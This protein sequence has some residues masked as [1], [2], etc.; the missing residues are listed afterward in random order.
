MLS[1][2]DNNKLE[3]ISNNKSLENYF[4]LHAKDPKWFYP[5]K[6]K[7]YFSPKKVPL[8]VETDQKGF[9]NV[10]DWSVLNYIESISK[11]CKDTDIQ[12]E[13]LSI[14]YNTT[15]LH[16]NSNFALDNYRVWW[17]FTKIL[18]NLPTVTVIKYLSDKNIDIGGNW[19]KGWLTSKFDNS[20][21]SQYI[22]DSILPKFLTNELG[23]RVIAESIIRVITDVV[24]RPKEISKG[25]YKDVRK[26]PQTLA[27]H[28]WL[29]R[30]ME[31]NADKIGALCSENVVFDLAAKLKK[32]FLVDRGDVFL[33]IQDHETELQFEISRINNDAILDDFNFNIKLFKLIK[34]TSSDSVVE[35]ERVAIT[36][37]INECRNKSDFYIALND[38]VKANFPNIV[39][40]DVEKADIERR[41]QLLF[42]DNSYIFHRSLLKEKADD[43]REAVGSLIFAI[44][45]ILISKAKHKPEEAK[46]IILEFLSV[47]YQFNFFKRLVVYVSCVYWKEFKEYFWQLLKKE[48]DLFVIPDYEVELYALLK[49]NVTSLT[50][51]EKEKINSAICHAAQS[52]RG[53]NAKKLAVRKQHWYSGMLH[54]DYFKGLFEE[55]KVLSGQ[56]EFKEPEQEFGM[57]EIGTGPSP[58]SLED[59]IKMPIPEL[60]RFLQDFKS[61]DTWNSSEISLSAT[62]QQAT[63]VAPHIFM[64]S[65][66]QFLPVKYLYVQNLIHGFGE[67]WKDKKDFDWGE[68]LQFCKQYL[69]KPDFGKPVV[70]AQSD[71]WKADHHWVASAIC[72]TIEIGLKETWPMPEKN[73]PD[74]EIVINTILER[75][76]LYRTQKQE[77]NNEEGALNVDHLT[78]ALNS[79]PGKATEALIQLY[80]LHV[81]RLV[82]KE[83]KKAHAVDLSKYDELLGKDIIEAYTFLGRHLNN[84]YYMNKEWALDK[85]KEVANIKSPNWYAFFSGYILGVGIYKNIYMA[86]RDSGHYDK[87]LSSKQYGIHGR[88][89]FVQH[90]TVG[91]LRGYEH[92]QDP[93]S[94]FRKLIERWTSEDLHEIVSFFWSQHNYFKKAELEEEDKKFISKI[95]E[96]WAW[97]V[98]EK[99]K[100]KSNLKDVAYP[101]F[102]SDL[103]RLTVYLDKI[104]ENNFEWLMLSASHVDL[105]FNSHFLIEY[106]DEIKDKDSLKWIGKIFRHMLERI[107]PIF[108]KENIESVVKKLYDGG[109]AEDADY[110]CNTYGSRG[111]DFL[112]PT[113]NEHR[114][115]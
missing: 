86:I 64:G 114:K 101:S 115:K 49:T 47:N 35:R 13:I 48:P 111:E 68:L 82:Q 73:V 65:L 34:K 31:T 4:F 29:N 44:K 53:L 81:N 39:L 71:H 16:N 61:K 15:A 40:S 66:L 84:F 25:F 56:T 33:N 106:L 62:L 5:L 78:N 107:T 2:Q 19:I 11:E 100:I 9:F 17:Y 3:L 14:I 12:N 97:C 93:K 80:M 27:N 98:N 36:A 45:A 51:D 26:N 46:N 105:N 76:D 103:A 104:D 24:W 43:F 94:L 102:L 1:P 92:L 6:A 87:A 7:G 54:D 91:Y 110:I 69:D 32:L 109:Y 60:I 50:I 41:Y 108:E 37:N 22:S 20:L 63:K 96:F 89:S 30:A 42:S 55:Q 21:T 95:I 85:I 10:P 77:K 88:Q 79:V 75:I 112:R 90:I 83:G 23:N 58:L 59:M 52:I 8:P 28:F 18:V 99:D 38:L 113:Y 70:F 57:V 74:V 67:A 72:D